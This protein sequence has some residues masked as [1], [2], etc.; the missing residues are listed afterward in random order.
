MENDE[1]NV[2]FDTPYSGL[3]VRSPDFT[4]EEALLKKAALHLD[5][6]IFLIPNI[7]PNQ[8]PSDIASQAKSVSSDY[9]SVWF[10]NFPQNLS[11]DQQQKL[12]QYQQD[13][14]EYR[15][16]SSLKWWTE[17]FQRIPPSSNSLVR[18]MQ[19]REL[20]KLACID[21][22][23]TPWLSTNKDT[24]THR[25]IQ[26]QTSEFHGRLISAVLFEFVQLDQAILDALEPLLMSIVRSISETTSFHDIKTIVTEKYEYDSSSNTIISHIRLV[27]FEVTEAFYNVKEGK[28]STQ[29]YVVCDMSFIDFEARFLPDQWKEYVVVIH[30]EQM[31][32]MQDFV[33]QQTVDV[34]P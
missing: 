31:E 3:I 34:P 2:P 9:P 24:N 30:A 13:I 26:C 28:S 4:E 32:A 12:Q 18:L 23:N 14:L 20:A 11:G 21:M 27:C 19:S 29:Q 33:N 17:V 5:P 8:S 10:I 1:G 22:R 7:P 25:Q 16:W 15:S 6:P